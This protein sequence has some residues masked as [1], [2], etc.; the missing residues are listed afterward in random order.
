MQKR[1]Y[2]KSILL[3]LLILIIAL[4]ALV[5]IPAKRDPKTVAYLQSVYPLAPVA[6]LNNAFFNSR[7]LY[8]Y[9]ATAT[10]D[11]FRDVVTQLAAGT[12]PEFVCLNWMLT[13]KPMGP[14]HAVVRNTYANGEQSSAPKA[15]PD[16]GLVEVYH[17]RWYREP[18][19]Y[20]Y[21]L[22]GSGI[23]LNVGHT[24]VALNKLDALRKL[25]LDDSQI[26]QRAAY[27]IIKN[28][29]ISS[30]ALIKVQADL[31]KRPF[32][33]ALSSA[34]QSGIDGSSYHFSR[35][36]QSSAPDYPLYLLARKKGYDTVQLTAQPN[37]NGGWAYELVD[38]R[39]PLSLSLKQKWMAAKKY[40]FIAD[41]FDHT[42]TAP[43]KFDVPFKI[44][45]CKSK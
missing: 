3:G 2:L 18:G 36:A 31:S 22:P 19:I 35:M 6:K 32:N 29:Y 8:W 41:P 16:N 13:C 10:Q 23:F 40:L 17:N 5:L 25:G 38:V 34:M 33:K 9:D 39:Q 15:T 44:L 12:E 24:L 26:L 7:T 42:H 20:Y 11:L 4:A 45:R 1:P 14:N 43:C 27:S 37:D 30:F 21:V 28:E